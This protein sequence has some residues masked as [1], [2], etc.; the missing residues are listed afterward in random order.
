[1][2]FNSLKNK[3]LFKN[4]TWGKREGGIRPD[5]YKNLSNSKKTYYYIIFLDTKAYNGGK[6]YAGK[7]RPPN[8]IVTEIYG[9]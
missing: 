2:Q 5:K 6:S 7:R 1:M 8:K 4:H 3:S 9:K